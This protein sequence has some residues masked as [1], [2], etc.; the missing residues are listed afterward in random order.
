MPGKRIFSLL[1]II[2]VFLTITVSGSIV[3]EDDYLKVHFIDV[4]QG[5]S[6]LLQSPQGK[7]I[8]IDGGDRWNWVSEKLVEYLGDQEVE[9]VHA[10]IS[11]HPHADHIGGLPAVINNFTVE[12]IYDSGR[13]HTTQTYENY[14]ELILEKEIP[15][16][17]PRRGDIIELGDLSFDVL[18]PAD[19]VEDYSLNNAS[20][21]LRLEYGEIS[22]LFTGDA[23][24]RAEKEIVET[25]DNIASDILKVGHHGSKTSSNDFFLDAVE[26]EISIIQLG[27]DN[28][29]G[30]PHEEVI[31]RLILR[32]I[33][34]YRND[35]HG[36]VVIFTDGENYQVE[37]ESEADPRA[38]P[39]EKLINI[40][41]ASVSNLQE[42]QGIGP[43]LAERI[44]EYRKDQGPFKII[45]EIKN[46]SGIGE[47]TF[48]NIK[49]DITV[50]NNME[51]DDKIKGKININTADKKQLAEL[52]GVCP[53]IAERII[54]VK[55]QPERPV[56]SH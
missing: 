47:G 33:D 6:I 56:F 51:E 9:T 2:L 54:E 52:W 3:S 4:G 15:Y 16:Y 30:H 38:P 31:E 5:S 24:E 50:G 39:E 10:I 45:E 1:A 43:S 53:V 41:T 49:D 48:N 44:I 21:V 12:K 28:R 40:N 11:T 32:E 7:N 27:E 14:L 37:V 46:V 19:D 29:Y 25:F 35:L 17:T 20:I 23:E 22:F 26:P 8:L 13:V 18:H 34:I 55:D 42:L 36:N